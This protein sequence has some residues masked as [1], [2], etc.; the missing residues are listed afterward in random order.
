MKNRKENQ[1]GLL[2]YLSGDQGSRP[3]V[4]QGN[5]EPNFFENVDIIED[6]KCGKALRCRP[7]QLLAYWAPGNIYAQRGTVAF[8]WRSRYPLGCTE[9]PIFRVGYADHSS[10]DAMFMRIDYNGGGI[11]AF[12]TDINLSRTRV[13]MKFDTLPSPDSWFH[14]AFAWDENVGVKLYI[15]GKLAAQQEKQAIYYAG[16]DQFG[17]H[18]RILSHWQVQ[19]SYNYMRTGD[20]DEIRIYDRMLEPQQVASLEKGED[21][22]FLPPLIRSLDEPI[23]QQEWLQRWGF[24]AQQIPAPL[25]HRYTAVHKVEIHN[26]WD[27]KRW[28]WKGCD[29]IRETTWPGVY[30]RSRLPGRTDYLILPDWD[31]YS[32]SGKEIT[33]D[34]LSD[35]YFNHIEI[36]GSAQGT[37]RIHGRLEE[38]HILQRVSCERS[39]HRLAEPV[40]NVSLTFTNEVIEEPIGD[41]TLLQVEQGMAPSESQRER[42]VFHWDTGNEVVEAVKA[43]CQF[44]EG[45]F[46]ADERALLIGTSEPTDLEIDGSKLGEYLPLVHLVMEYRAGDEVGMDGIVLRFPGLQASPTH[47]KYLLVNVQVKDPLWL[48]RNLLQFTFAV[49]PGEE[50]EIWL[51][52]R[53][54]ILP[55]GKALYVTI[56]FSGQVAEASLSGLEA[57]IV[58]KPAELAKEE[59]VA[60]RWIQVKDNYAHLVEE[61]PSSEKFNLYNRFLGD[62]KDLL[63]VCPEHHLARL[64][65]YDKFK[66]VAPVYRQ[67]PCPPDVPLWAW[68]QVEYLG[69][70]KRYIR[71]WIDKRQID[72]GEFGGGLSDDGDLT[73]WW[74]GP[75][76]A[77]CMPQKIKDSLLLMMEAFYDQGM[78]SNGLCA[79]QTDQLHTL[80]EGVQALGQCL[81]LDPCSPKH[82]ER[83]MENARGLFY[84]TDYNAV[85]HRHF[86][87]GYYSG[88]RVAEEAP[89]NY[90]AS[91]SFHVLHP[92]YMLVR[93]NGSP[94]AKKLILEL[95]DAMM[96][97]YYDGKLHVLINVETD[98]DQVHERTRE[99]PLFYAA[100][101]FTGDEKYLQPIN[102]L[103]YAQPQDRLQG[104]AENIATKLAQQYESLI[105]SAALRE[106]I[107]TDGQLW[108]D[109]GVIDIGVVQEHRIGGIGH[110][111]FSLYPRHYL[112]WQFAPGQ[113]E[114]VAILVTYASTT[115][116]RIS[117]WNM[118]DEQI[119]AGLVLENILPGQWRIKQGKGSTI[120]AIEAVRQDEQVKL[121][122][123]M[124][125][126]I[127]FMPGEYTVLELDLEQASAPYW[128][129]PDLAI[130][131]EDVIVSDS[132]IRVRI[133]NIGAVVSPVT[134]VA[135]K[136]GDG[137]VLRSSQVPPLPAP[138]D[139]YPKTVEVSL[140]TR[141]LSLEGCSIEIDPEGKLEEITKNNNRIML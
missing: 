33:F 63:R 3:E 90:S 67:T 35:T 68:R 28:W 56:A 71:W 7:D 20:F 37:L 121:E 25:C 140:W 19:S 57:E 47:G 5:P 81:T 9:F 115:K 17:T 65:W 98:A 82:L 30:N 117:A 42:F 10:W 134:T 79:I 91:D 27:L 36:S 31:C 80:E 113:E 77:G 48:Y 44:V 85:G 135:L 14:I 141:G 136:S 100:W 133:H 16:L 61:N 18:S 92:A 126:D 132:C 83:A 39:V 101:Q 94:V 11:D 130:D 6:G 15:D 22:G 8:F 58:Y 128:E 23:W 95:A 122:R 124:K 123:F 87:S 86:K 137:T 93:Y 109:R 2:F 76:L 60:D 21:I 24:D 125:Q 54:R 50:K 72:N 108:V 89:W 43:V 40:R 55:E 38:Q 34:P 70:V 26:A 127:C 116:L 110:E 69:Y 99:W 29:G 53:D 102:Q 88:N 120:G 112:R 12:V 41:I 138:V 13:S 75:A 114:D 45:R 106:Y 97:H 74:P 49:L 66:D 105:A 59:H 52:T 107:N 1:A 46:M 62:I 84:V 64:Y 32:L 111:R 119:F 103:L 139:L 78:F 129:R 51:D 118:T 131:R 104:E 96:D 73:A 4:A